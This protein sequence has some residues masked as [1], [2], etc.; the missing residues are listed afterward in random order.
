MFHL[1]YFHCVMINLNYLHC[2]FHLNYL[3]I[4]ILYMAW[5]CAYIYTE[6]FSFSPPP[7][8]VVS[9]NLLPHYLYEASSHHVT[10]SHSS[11]VHLLDLVKYML[12][13]ILP[14][15]VI[16]VLFSIFHIFPKYF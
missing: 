12:N 6:I 7:S 1:N 8:T 4:T 5:L 11:V 2:M 15:D 10:I 13:G 9:I 16:G 14:F 3:H